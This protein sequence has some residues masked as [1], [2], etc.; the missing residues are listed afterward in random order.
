[1]TRRTILALA[2]AAVGTWLRPAWAGSAG[3]RAG[4]PPAPAEADP[5][6][7]L[8]LRVP[9][10]TANGAKVPI[11][12]ESP[13]PMTP[14]HHVTRLRVSNANDPISVKGTFDLT[15]ANGRVYVAFQARMHEGASEV[16]AT[17][18]CN[19]HGEFSTR[20]PIVI[21]EGAG[22]C[23]SAGAPRIGRTAGEDIR[24]PVIRIAELVERGTIRA[25]ELVHVQVKMRHPNRT[26]LAFRD[27]RFV[28]ES[29]PIHV[30]AVDVFYGGE[31]VSHFSMTAALSDDPMIGFGLLARSSGTLRV[32]ITNS[33]GQRFV[34]A[35]ELE[36]A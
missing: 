20:S 31:P 12:V 8:E 27:G 5:E 29:A 34:A 6:H 30:D 11:F 13:H 7:V 17:A 25:G 3:E 26:G 4:S 9:R 24:A 16:T 14:G 28:Q 36:V 33:R 32:A 10:F 21:P 35:R 2:S 15:P 1:L 22:G 23:M 19:L 18:E